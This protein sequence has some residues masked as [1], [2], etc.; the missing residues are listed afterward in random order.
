[1][2]ATEAAMAAVRSN[3]LICGIFAGISPE[4]YAAMADGWQATYSLLFDTPE[5]PFVAN[6]GPHH[7]EAIEWHWNARLDLLNGE[8]PDYW[9]YFPI[10]SRG[11]MKS[12]VARRIA[13]MD[14]LLTVAYGEAGY[15]LYVS[16]NK[17]MATKHAASIETILGSEIIRRHCP[18]LSQVKKNAANNSKGWKAT[19]LN[20][21]A[22]IVF[23]FAGLDEGLAG[24]N[25][26]DVRP[27]FILPDDIDGRESS[28]TE[29]ENRFNKLT[30]EV[31]PMR[32][33]NTL[34]F[35]AQNLI[36]RYSAMYRIQS[37]MERV[38]TN[39]KPT[40][41]IPAVLNPE[42]E[43]QTVG[44]IVKDVIVGGTPTW[45]FYN[46]ERCQEEIE[47]IGLEAFKRECQHEVAQSKEGLIAHRFDDEV[48][49]IS[50]SE[51]AA[52]Y[53]SKDAW[54]FW[55]KW[56]MNDWARTKTD[57]H[58]NVAAF[59]TISPQI[60]PFPGA[61]FICAPLAFPANT[62]PEDVAEALLS[63]LTPFA[64]A[65]VTWS[66]L[67]RDAHLRVNSQRHA[68]TQRERIE[69]ERS[70]LSKTVKKY[71]KAAL[72]R[73]KVKG[74]TMGHSDDTVESIYRDVFGFKVVGV[75]PGKHGGIEKLNQEMMVDYNEPH[76][77]RPDQL[78]YSRW[79][80]VVPD[81]PE[82]KEPQIVNGKEV[83][84]PKPYPHSV[85]PHELYNDDLLRYQLSNWRYRE[86]KLTETGEIVD[87]PLKMN[88]DFGNMLQM[89]Y[90]E[91]RPKNDSL[92]E[93][94]TTEQFISPEIQKFKDK[95]NRTKGEQLAYDEEWREANKKVK[96]IYD[97][98][99]NTGGGDDA[100]EEGIEHFNLRE[101]I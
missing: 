92:T 45:A 3:Q 71:S 41:P 67:R 33:S 100:Y 91:K 24:G 4:L 75:N 78:G 69:F 42:Y 48:H 63:K 27:T 29:G 5:R 82:D 6:L 28:P 32:Q 17:E 40:E 84:R 25:V 74:G 8:K 70:N 34:Q 30:T 54:K 59:L 13:V 37:G 9:T 66:K 79:F 101:F 73:F 26:D 60:S 2:S 77:F 61:T 86:A 64:Y 89:F 12:T 93:T 68:Q 58:A 21:L 47:T 14:A 10:W 90:V 98:N 44:G 53:G 7:A 81:D 39:R 23:H 96:K 99:L 22:G 88:D 18:T 49:V 46:L 56:T 16:R 72:A 65:R 43:V 85:R 51:F 19:F 62:E 94:E 55:S 11:H 95:P 97:V 1:M 57:K 20:T 80:I 15:V 36:N 87:E 31:L 83:F 50:E 38:L 52:V 76:P 35:W